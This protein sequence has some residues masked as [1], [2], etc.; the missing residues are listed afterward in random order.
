MKLKIYQYFFL[1]VRNM[2][3]EQIKNL[4]EFLRGS[5]LVP[6]RIKDNKKRVNDSSRAASIVDDSGFY[7]V[8][9]N[10]VTLVVTPECDMF[11]AT[12][13]LPQI[14]E[15]RRSNDTCSAGFNNFVAGEAGY[16][17]KQYKPEWFMEKDDVGYRSPLYGNYLSWKLLD[18]FLLFCDKTGKGLLWKENSPGWRGT[19]KAG[20]LY[21]VQDEAD[22]GTNTF[23]IGRCWSI[24]RRMKAYGKERK[25]LGY[26]YVNDH[27]EAEK[28]LIRY[29]AERF[30]H[31]LDN[32]GRQI[33]NEYFT[34]ASVDVAIRAFNKAIEEIRRAGK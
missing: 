21:L 6:I 4:P 9:F 12:K 29:F 2:Q 3:S 13:L 15:R 22:V 17:M 33:G 5:T 25:E 10:G 18:T 34:C 7:K 31:A 8:A 16:N 32:K 11:N 1:F 27:H 23:K 19:C 24:D 20:H 30:D 28:I 14:C 26:E